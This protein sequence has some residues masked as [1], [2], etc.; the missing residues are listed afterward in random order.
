MK[1]QTLLIILTISLLVQLAQAQTCKNTQEP[2]N[3]PS[4]ATALTGKACAIGEAEKSDQDLILWTVSEEDAKKFWILELEG[5]KNQLSELE[6]LRVTLAEDGSTVTARETLLTLS[7][8]DGNL[9]SS[10]PLIFAP[11]TY[12]LGMVSAGEGGYYLN[13]RPDKHPNNPSANRN[14]PSN[15]DY[16]PNESTEEASIVKGAFSFAGDIVGSP[17]YYRWEVSEEEAKQLW[18]LQAQAMLGSEL[19]IKIFDSSGEQVTVAS[20]EGSD[21]LAINNLGLIADTYT[22]VLSPPSKLPTPYV[23]STAPLGIPTD[24][25]EIE[26]NNTFKE[27]NILKP[28]APMVGDL[29]TQGSDYFRFTINSV[30]ETRSIQLKLDKQI[31]INLCLYDNEGTRLKCQSSENTA[32]TNLKL[33]GD[34]GLS[35]SPVGVQEEG[36][37]YALS[38]V[39]ENVAKPGFETEP[40]DRSEDAFVLN[41]SNAVR[42]N[43]VA[44]EYDFFQ[45]TVEGNPQLWRIQAVG[46]GIRNLELTNLAGRQMQARGVNVGEKRIRL[47]NL[48][49][50][51]GTYF[52]SLL[53]QDTDY[54][55]RAVSLGP[56]DEL[57]ESLTPLEDSVEPL[58]EEAELAV[59]DDFRVIIPGPR[60][61][62]LIEQ[63]PNDVPGSAE[64]LRFDAPRVGLLPSGDAD[65]YR[66]FLAAEQYIK[67]EVTPPKDAQ[68]QISFDSDIRTIS[69]ELGAV[70]MYE[71]LL[72]PGD[73]VVTLKAWTPSEGFYQLRLTQ[74]DP[75]AVPA[76]LEPNNRQEQARPLPAAFDV[77][78]T[79]G[80]YNDQDW[81]RLPI[82]SQETQ[83]TIAM[84]GAVSDLAFMVGEEVLEFYFDREANAYQGV[85]PADTIVDLRLRGRGEGDYS[86]DFT[87]DNA[88]EI[89]DLPDIALTLESNVKE[90]AAYWHEGQ[91]IPLSL[92][93]KN[94]SDSE[95]ALTLQNASSDHNWTPSFK[96]ES[97]TLAAGEQETLSGQIEVLADARDDQPVLI[98]AGVAN[99]QSFINSTSLSITPSCIAPTVNAQ[100]I[101]PLPKE[102]LGGLNVAWAGLGSQVVG[103]NRFAPD[104]FDGTLSGSRGAQR[105]LGEVITVELAGNE[106]VKLLGTLLHPQASVHRDEQLKDFDILVSLDGETFTEIFSGELSAVKTEQ[107][108]IFDEPVE[109]RFA[110]IRLNNNYGIKTHAGFGEWKLITAP[111]VLKGPFNIADPALGGNVVYSDPF[112]GWKDAI[113]TAKNEGQF[114]VRPRDNIYEWVVGF[115]HY[116]AAQ[117]TELQWLDSPDQRP[118]QYLQKVE[119]EVSLEEPVGPWQS[120][121]TWELERSEDGIAPLKLESPIWARF[122]RF[123][124]SDPET[125]YAPTVPQQIIVLERASDEEYQSIL[126]EWGMNSRNSIYEW[127]NPPV[128]DAIISDDDNNDSRE[129]VQLLELDKDFSGRVLVE[130][131]IDWLRIDIPE[132]HNILNITLRGD[133]SIDYQFELQNEVGQAVAAHISG[134]NLRHNEIVLTANVTSGSYFL[135]I[136]EPPRSVVFSW[137]TSGSVGPFYDVIDQTMA[138]FAQEVKEGREEVNLLP[139]ADTELEFLLRD[140]SGDASTVMSAVA[141]SD[142]R[143]SSSNAESALTLSTLG[144]RDRF[145]TRAIMFIT[146]AE[147]DGIKLTPSLWQALKEIKPRIFSF[148]ISSRGSTYTQDMLQSWA[149][150]NN[151]VYDLAINTGDLEIGFARATCMLRRPKTYHVRAKAIFE[152]PTG[153]G[154]LKV[155]QKEFSDLELEEEA[156]SSS[157]AVEVILDASG[158]MFKKLED[159]FRYVI[160]KEVLSDLVANTL[161][162][163][164]P[165][166]LR[167]FGN[168]EEQSCR[169]DLEVPLG[170]LERES[171]QEVIAGIVPQAFAGTPIADSLLQVASDLSGSDGPKTVILITDG[172]ESCDGDVEAAIQSLKDQ[173]IDVQLNIIGFDFDADDKEKARQQFRAW[174]ELGGGKYF[175]ANSAEE[176][177]L[178]LTQAVQAPT[179]VTFEVIDSQE[180]VIATGTVNGEALELP[181]GNYKLQIMTAEPYIIDVQILA[182]ETKQLEIEQE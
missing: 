129:N 39:N 34:Y 73:H 20:I 5:P 130:E 182:E 171:V 61:E 104:A 146:D 151:G 14:L 139:F 22:L 99:E 91:K 46:E 40:N 112:T 3:M 135:K 29:D 164:V 144:L 110:Q 43:L 56:P 32:L 152:E 125:G 147:T 111:D 85:I 18:Q 11:G 143:A 48:L 153:P 21:N 141:N 138:Q 116:R 27:A 115:H 94:N 128:I 72:L 60:P 66:F 114:Q 45:F 96:Q 57:L 70:A 119:I 181:A 80:Q 93:I 126:G 79:I 133:P 12:I 90:V 47:D 124:A 176:L 162:D 113:V 117:I 120:L 161:P 25:Q 165:F 88:P 86:L 44:S 26:P 77:S 54:A 28:E 142:R 38:I 155:V 180:K 37:P 82:L 172:E 95:Q 53:G 36:I 23:I 158:S 69:S 145:G 59:E 149:G 163:D 89:G 83:M 55:L 78:G 4:E 13:L 49:L 109:A 160:A 150:V 52:I 159:K 87:F 175:D 65:V 41:D 31:R 121:A 178:S 137:D 102:L 50:F 9:E 122:V 33:S 132:N 131:D 179:E 19:T 98:T 74:L 17:D 154:F 63:E 174:A 6:V 75:L 35:V 71:G 105:S 123:R 134:D 156:V 177:E 2:D 167:V 64:R 100:Q 10:Q 173:G 170:V 118:E 81:F 97:L 107:A 136:E 101:W 103:D 62:G 106:P 24:G 51:P 168:R 1:Q 8:P 140:W 76:D 84:K 67:F 127:L 42:G 68:V 58:Q 108:F 92:T 148:E 30:E 169:T 7:T 16:E 15:R 166:A 157:V